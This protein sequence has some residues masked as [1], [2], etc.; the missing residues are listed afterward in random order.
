MKEH[1]EGDRRRVTRRSVTESALARPEAAQGVVERALAN[2][3]LRS[4]SETNLG[5]RARALGEQ[6]A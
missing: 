3:I 1:L 2:M 6:G 5:A 4:V